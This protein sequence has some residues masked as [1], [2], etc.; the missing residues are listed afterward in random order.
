MRTIWVAFVMIGC[1][2]D[3]ACEAYAEGE[4]DTGIFGATF[5]S[6]GTRAD[7]GEIDDSTFT[8]GNT[9]ADLGYGPDGLPVQ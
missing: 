5:C 7:C 9:C 4:G 8:A 6:D 2:A 1:N 3:G